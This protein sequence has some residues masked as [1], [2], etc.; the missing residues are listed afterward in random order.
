VV[1]LASPD[2]VADDLAERRLAARTIERAGAEGAERLQ[3]PAAGVL[4]EIDLQR[5]D[6][7]RRD[8]A[9]ADLVARERGTVDD[10]HVG[11]GGEEGACAGGSRRSAPDDEDVA[12]THRR[13][14]RGNGASMAGRSPSAVR[15]SPG[16]AAC[17]RRGTPPASRRGRVA[18]CVRSARRTS[19]G[20]DRRAARTARATP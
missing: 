17:R 5:V 14:R 20:S 4:V 7:G 1:E 18:T 13:P 12:L 15:R 2:A 11:T 19:R 6:D 16:T 3:R 10:E 9:G 8:P